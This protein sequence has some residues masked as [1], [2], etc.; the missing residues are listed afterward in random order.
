MIQAE[1]E[2][3]KAPV[4]IKS[5]TKTKPKVV[6]TKTTQDGTVIELH[7]LRINRRMKFLISNNKTKDCTKTVLKLSELLKPIL[8]EVTAKPF[9]IEK[10]KSYLIKIDFN[11]K[12]SPKENYR[13]FKDLR[14]RF[15][16]IFNE[17]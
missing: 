13:K 4:K 16:R 10:N 8:K 15:K 5:T 2:R 14:N 12:P 1:T 17:L 7:Q 11:K 9:T 6:F 3:K